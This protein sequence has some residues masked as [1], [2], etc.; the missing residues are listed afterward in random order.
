MVVMLGKSVDSSAKL[1]L[2]LSRLHDRL[3][4][5]EMKQKTKQTIDWW[6]SCTRVVI[7]ATSK[8]M[9]HQSFHLHL[10]PL[11]SMAS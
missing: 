1:R 2:L 5:E 6:H 8:S 7:P 9:N 11:T 10:L 3:K 4:E